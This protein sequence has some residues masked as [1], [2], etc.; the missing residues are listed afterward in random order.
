MEMQAAKPN[1]I[2]S[3]KNEFKYITLSKMIKIQIG[4][5]LY[6]L[7]IDLLVKAGFGTSA[8]VVLEGAVAKL[9]SISLGLAVIL[10]SIVVLI[11]SYFL[12]QNFGWG[13]F[14][15]MIF[16]GVWVDILKKCIFANIPELN[17]YVNIVL[18][19]LGIVFMGLATAVYVGVG[20]GAGPRD[21]LMLGVA[22]KFKIS[23]RRART[24][25]EIAVVL[26]GFLL[27]GPLGIGTLIFAVCIGPSV[28]FWFKQLKVV[29]K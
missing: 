21:S 3:L 26:I 15:N 10:V 9:F 28:Q 7:S 25:I 24:I 6:G 19:V 1:L 14:L 22:Q 12:K 11:L 18:F 27:Q 20:A 29:G 2:E 5:M 4:F 13:T 8:W 17:I 23:V 16:I